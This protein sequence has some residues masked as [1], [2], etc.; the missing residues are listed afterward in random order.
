MS[1]IW[2]V[3]PEERTLDLSWT[4]S[5]GKAQPFWIRV[6]RHLTVGEERRVMTAGWKS[7]GGLVGGGRGRE[8]AEPEI[9]IDWRAQ[10]FARTE[11]YLLD[12]SFED[13]EKRK[14]PVTRDV[15]EALQ[16]EVFKLIED[17]I[18]KHIEEME[19]EKKAS[20]VS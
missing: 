8:Q 16:P 5:E 11:A 7:V 9:K 1:S 6:K 2:T 12:W 3:K 18:T 15:I 13:D 4:T 20:P 17:A 10:S 14:L 19:Q